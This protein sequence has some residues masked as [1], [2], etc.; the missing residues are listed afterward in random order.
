VKVLTIVTA[1]F[2]SLAV[3]SGVYGMNFERSFP[4]FDW[5]YGFPFALGIMALSVIMMLALFRRLRLL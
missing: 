3:I 4:P 2:A 5:P 1:I